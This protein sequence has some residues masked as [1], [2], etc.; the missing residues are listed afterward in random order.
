MLVFGMLQ[1][2]NYYYIYLY[3]IKVYK[4]LG[5]GDVNNAYVLFFIFLKDSSSHAEARLWHHEAAVD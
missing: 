3:D 2:M 1:C 4:S 5:G